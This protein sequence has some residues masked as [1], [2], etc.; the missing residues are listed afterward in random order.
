MSIVSSFTDSGSNE[1][2]DINSEPR[3]S[4]SVFVAQE[5]VSVEVLDNFLASKNLR[6]ILRRL[7][8]RN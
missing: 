2:W 3:R 6:I 5:V 4:K 7:M 1:I 8:G